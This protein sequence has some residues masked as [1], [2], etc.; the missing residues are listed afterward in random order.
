MKL[1]TLLTALLALAVALPALAASIRFPDVP[2]DHPNSEA[3]HWARE[4][5]LFKGYPDG[6]FQPAKELSENELRIVV[7]RLFDRYD[8]W[9]RADTAEFLHA[10]DQA[11][12]NT[13]AATTTSTAPA[14]TQAVETTTITEPAGSE[15]QP[16]THR[17]GGANIALDV[18]F[19]TRQGELLEVL[20]NR[21]DRRLPAWRYRMLTFNEE[22]ADDPAEEWYNVRAFST[23][24]LTLLPPCLDNLDKFAVQVQWDDGWQQSEICRKEKDLSEFLGHRWVCPQPNDLHQWNVLPAAW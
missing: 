13:A 1:R 22:C 6:R 12:R 23:Q 18:S 2:A 16:S 8:A 5:G 11:L 19:V 7:K 20:W 3:I 10:G 9:T 17:R 24:V 4:E 14:T 15:E 21:T